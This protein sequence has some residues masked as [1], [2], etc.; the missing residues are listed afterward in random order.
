M[1][2]RRHRV[3]AVLAGSG[4]VLA[5]AIPGLVVSAPSALAAGNPV[6]NPGLEG[7]SK[8]YPKCW[9]AWRFGSGKATGKIVGKAHG[10]KRAF[11]IKAQRMQGQRALVQT[12]A[13]AIKVRPN[14]SLALSVFYKSTTNKAAIQLF[15]R[16]AKGRWSRW[17]TLKSVPKSPAKW[18]KAT[19]RTP[20]VPPGTT[21]VRWGLSLYGKGTLTTDDYATQ[22]KT[23]PSV[24]A[25]YGMWKVIQKEAPIRG[26][27]AVLLHNGN[28]LLIEGSGGQVANFD[29]FDKGTFNTQ[30][31]NPR[32]NTF[33]KVNTPVDLFCAGHVQMANGNVMVLGG[34]RTAPGEGDPDDP[35]V[36]PANSGFTG[37]KQAY[38]FVPK[39]GGGYYKRVNDPIDGHWYPSATILGNG[40]IFS[41]GG[42]RAFPAAGG[43]LI[44]PYAERW[45]QKQKRWLSADKVRQDFSKEWATYPSLILMGNG[46]LFYTGSHAFS[47][48]AKTVGVENK[49]GIYDDGNNTKKP[50]F[51]PL[52]GLRDEGTRD[53]SMSVLLPPAQAQKVLT[54]GG[55]NSVKDQPSGTVIKQVPAVASADIIDLKKGAKATYHAAHGGDL[56]QG[57]MYVSAVILPNGKVFETGGG[58]HLKSDPVFEAS[59]FDP[60]SEKF[61]PMAADPV[62]RLYHSSAFLLPDGRVMAIG[63]QN[64]LADAINYDHHIS[65]YSPPYLFKG[66]RPKVAGVPAS[67]VRGTKK[68]IKISK[69]IKSAVLIRPAAVTHSSD[70]NQRSVQLSIGAQKGGK[71]TLGLAKNPH[72]TP[73]GY[74]ML[75]VVDKAGVPS[76]AKWV[77]IK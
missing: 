28:V 41:V 29:R 33:T 20:V 23:V 57:K 64:N 49:P 60:V 37:L 51:T 15:V 47:Y 70:P 54:L 42:H 18:R 35:T 50:V 46:R 73:P 77:L 71:L 56:R 30:V 69:K 62:G 19:A 4:L 53:A 27:H 61:A 38:V 12:P 8:G 31:Y 58:K 24:P 5:T 26:I 17:T 75:F 34:T 65:F 45:S 25:R 68:T 66:P 48:G 22:A 39:G 9:T 10:G 76:V 1:K 63:S 32:T 6:K 43:Q 67:W 55:G 21:H 40:D 3:R 74:Y 36:D 16:N 72:L 13:C 44:S 59:M 2:F 7:S 11:E 14:T 52:G